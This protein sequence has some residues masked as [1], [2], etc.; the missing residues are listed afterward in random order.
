MVV[1]NVEITVGIDRNVPGIGERGGHG[2]LRISSIRG[3]QLNYAAASIVDDIHIAA[4]VH[5]DA[6]GILPSCAE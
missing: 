3:S 1:G 5:S 6:G 4:A 2:G